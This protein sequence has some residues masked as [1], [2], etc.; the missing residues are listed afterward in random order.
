[1]H[2]NDDHHDYQIATGNAGWQVQ[3]RCR[4]SRRKSAAAQLSTLG[5]YPH[6]SIQAIL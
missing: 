5:D 3:F 4:G 6:E 1:M 2:R